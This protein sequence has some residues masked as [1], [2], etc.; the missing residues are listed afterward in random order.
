[1]PA[2]PAVSA[3]ALENIW[4]LCF[5]GACPRRLRPEEQTLCLTRRHPWRSLRASPGAGRAPS[6]LRSRDGGTS[7]PHGHA[8]LRIF[9]QTSRPRSTPRPPVAGSASL[10]GARGGFPRASRA[11]SPAFFPH[12]GRLSPGPHLL[13]RMV[14]GLRERSR[15]LRS[16]TAHDPGLRRGGARPRPGKC[17][18]GPLRRCAA[19]FAT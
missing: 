18:R 9:S 7:P 4:G 13:P 12:R 15:R 3:S 6:R 17:T 14:G 8:V 11:G 5:R 10:H 16:L 1:M 19:S 2:L